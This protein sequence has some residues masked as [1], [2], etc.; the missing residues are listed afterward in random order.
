MKHTEPLTEFEVDSSGTL[1]VANFWE[2]RNRAGFYEYVYDS[3]SGSP[4]HLT[5]AMAE[6]EPLAWAVHSIYTDVRDEIQSD[7][8]KIM[9]SSGLTHKS[10]DALTVRLNAMPEE[11]EEGVRAWL[12]NLTFS[13]FQT[14][15]VAE[16]SKWFNSPPDWRWED[17]HLPQG[18][19]AQ[20]AAL[21]FFQNMDINA[22]NTLGVKIVEG[23]HPGSTYYAA[24]LTGDID[25][26]NRIAADAGIP[27]RF[28]RGS[29]PAL[30]PLA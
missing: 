29:D 2:P 3:W 27:V 5:D 21:E 11:P 16:I 26:A 25:A 24:E 7:L 1:R 23:D 15:V 17:D 22:L 4:A 30:E 12:L 14:I 20:G 6:C 19:T 13:E 8:E 18:G 9:S 10:A 28:R